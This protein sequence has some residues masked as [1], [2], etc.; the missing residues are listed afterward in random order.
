MTAPDGTSKASA[1][2]GPPFGVGLTLCG[3]AII[4]LFCGAFGAWSVMAPIKG[5][6]VAPGVVSVTLL[7]ATGAPLQ[8]PAGT[9]RADCWVH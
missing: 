3:F 8:P 2:F 5:A 4:A 1:D 7:N 6:V 9:V